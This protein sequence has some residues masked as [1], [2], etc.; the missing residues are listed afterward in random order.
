VGNHL[1]VRA[2]S[3]FQAAPFG[4]LVSFGGADRGLV[5]LLLGHAGAAPLGRLRLAVVRNVFTLR[6]LLA[7]HAKGTSDLDY[8]GK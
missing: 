1:F 5:L 6:K 4:H 2:T 8:S 7:R 3:A